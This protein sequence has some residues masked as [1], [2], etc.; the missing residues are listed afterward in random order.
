MGYIE[1][2]RKLVGQRP[3]IMVGATALIL[4]ENERLLM[5]RRTDNGCWGV[6]GGAMEP[7]ESLE[8]TARR[9][10]TEE[11]GLEIGEMSLYRIFSGPEFYYEYPN[12]DQ[13]YIVT[14]VF[15]TRDFHGQIM[16]NR[17]EHTDWQF[18][19]VFHLPEDLSPPI[20]PILQSFTDMHRE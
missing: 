20:K 11:T 8:D 9:E 15:L 4:D 1:E 18:F 10:T 6:P 19:D 7:G 12:G 16:I 5:L 13:V 14:A 17:E 3:I 2:I